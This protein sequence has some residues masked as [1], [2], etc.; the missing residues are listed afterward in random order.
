MA[1]LKRRLIQAGLASFAATG[2]HRWLAPLTRGRGAILTFHHVRPWVPRGFAPNRL[3]EITPE[4]FD[5]LLGHLRASGTD[6]VTMD[7]VLPR[8]ATKGPPFVALTFDDGYR[9]N[10][11]HALPICKRHGAPL[12]VFVT[13]GFADG[14]TPLWWLD[15]EAIVR[16]NDRLTVVLDGNANA[17]PLRTDAEKQRGFD[18][19]AKVLITSAPDRLR[20]IMA[21]LGQ[22]QTGSAATEA[23]CLGWDDLSTLA[24]HPLVT[25]GCHTLSHS[26]LAQLDAGAL[27]QELAGSRAGIAARLGCPVRHLA[28]PYGSS[29]AAAAREFAV[30]REV[31]FTTAVTTR[32]GTLVTA[33]AGTPTA[34]PR[35]S[36]NGLW[37]DLRYVE[38]L[39]SGAPFALWN[40]ARRDDQP[41]EG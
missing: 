31:G 39:L 26:N 38:V 34:L 28:Y 21:S 40:G 36:I 2:L 23:L 20:S 37:Q 35:I 7:E 1:A 4:F 41:T 18:R 16:R 14:I 17:L 29:R 12:C 6:L 25:I 15:L 22:P 10:L 27:R 9:D 24:R 30:A 5:A 32:P 8:L 3:L 33:H 11:V 19:I 13:N